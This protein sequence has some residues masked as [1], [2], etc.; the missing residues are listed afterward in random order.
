MSDPL[1]PA[2][3]A[4]AKPPDSIETAAARAFLA[5][6]AVAEANGFRAM[7]VLTAPDG[8]MRWHHDN[9][10]LFEGTVRAIIRQIGG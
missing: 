1:P 7:I 5:A 6:K 8:T 3:A 4:E 10:L 9:A 2:P